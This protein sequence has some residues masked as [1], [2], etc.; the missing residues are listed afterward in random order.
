MIFGQGFFRGYDVSFD[1]ETDRVGFSENQIEADKNLDPMSLTL[2]ALM[3]LA[4]LSITAFMIY[5]TLYKRRVHKQQ[6]ALIE[7]EE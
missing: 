3:M 2:F 6:A 7:T 1:Y 5:F 4:V